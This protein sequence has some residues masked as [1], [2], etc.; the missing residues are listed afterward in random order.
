VL[1][2]ARED[3]ARA[4]L[5][6]HSERSVALGFVGAPTFVVGDEIFWGN[7]RLEAALSWRG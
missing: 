7:D 5:R 3:V 6:E 2:A 4:R 1:A